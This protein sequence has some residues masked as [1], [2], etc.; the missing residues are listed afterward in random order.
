MIRLIA[1]LA[2][3]FGHSYGIQ[4]T[5]G[6]VDFVT[7]FIGIECPGSLAVYAF[8]LTSGLLI[9][10]SF[11]RQNNPVK[12]GVLRFARIWPGLCV[13]VLVTVF[14]IGPFFTNAS[15]RDYVFAVGT[16]KYVTINIF[17]FGKVVATIPGLFPHSWQPNGV[18]FPLWTL[19]VEVQ[20]YLMVF[21]LGMLGL[22]RRMWLMLAA[23]ALA[24]TAFLVI[25]PHETHWPSSRYFFYFFHLVQG[26]SFYPVPFFMIGIA[27]YVLREKIVLNGYF[28]VLLMTAYLWLQHTQA[29]Q[30]LLYMAYIYGL[31]VIAGMAS[32]QFLRPSNDYSY[33]VYI[34]GFVCEQIV[35]STW[36]KMDN[37]IGLLI[38]IPLTLLFA[39]ASW[40]TIEKPALKFARKFSENGNPFPILLTNYFKLKGYLF[41]RLVQPQAAKDELNFFPM[42]KVTVNEEL[43]N[44]PVQDEVL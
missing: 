34:Y 38:V 19:P 11:D 37:Y 30:P 28:A 17:Q 14:L 18:N 3:I 42:T 23:L 39:A 10:Q 41:L 27:C 2:V 32:I 36:P 15:L 43:L 12:F 4:N 16:L 6:N 13:N 44:Q 35:A 1:A 8:F 20:C 31:L 21:A 24:L 7:C 22:F 26:Y 33:G 40:H 9:A 29:G 5:Q 25:A